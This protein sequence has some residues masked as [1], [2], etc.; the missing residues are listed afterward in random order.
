MTIS[1]LQ[2]TC[3]R[4]GEHGKASVPSAAEADVARPGPV[5]QPRNRYVKKGKRRLGLMRE[6]SADPHLWRTLF[7]LGRRTIDHTR[8]ELSTA[9]G[10]AGFH[11]DGLHLQGWR[12]R[13]DASCQVSQDIFGVALEFNG[14]R[15]T[16]GR[17]ALQR[18][19]ETDH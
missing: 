11:Y 13:A 4:P 7:A 16:L 14:G 17:G 10:S 5:L 9:S 3:H 18:Q 12:R 6:L 15:A 1:A 19:L 8:L 2:T